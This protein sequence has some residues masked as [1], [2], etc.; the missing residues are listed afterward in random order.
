M[1]WVHWCKI[2]MDMSRRLSMSLC[3]YITMLNGKCQLE[4]QL[5]KWL[6]FGDWFIKTWPLSLY[7]F[8]FCL[9]VCDISRNLFSEGFIAFKDNKYSE[10]ISKNACEPFKKVNEVHSLLNIHCSYDRASTWKVY[11]TIL[12]RF[13]C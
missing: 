3:L 7:G 11:E 2:L 12:F 4:F 1:E 6:S 9:K 13:L 8:I 5:S 10:N